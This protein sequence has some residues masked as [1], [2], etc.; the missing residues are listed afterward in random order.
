[1]LAGILF[2]TLI[3]VV[4]ALI[5]VDVVRT[6]TEAPAG[7]A[8][9]HGPERAAVGARAATEV[10]AFSREPAGTDKAAARATGG[11]RFGTVPAEMDSVGRPDEAARTFDQMRREMPQSAASDAALRSRFSAM[12]VNLSR[13]SQA[14][15]ERQ[16]RL[17]ESL[18]HGEQDQHRLATL[19]KLNRIA[20]R[21]HRNSQNLLVLAGQE[22]VSS[23]NQPVTL[24]HLVEA[25]LAEIEDY[26]RV[27]FEVQPDIALR[28][29]AVHDAV[30]LL[31]ELIDNAT[32]FSAAEMPVHITGRILTTGGALVDITDRGIGMPAKEMAYANQQLDNPP[33]PETDVPKWMGL[34]VVARLAARH[35]IRVRLNPTDI[36]GL[37][38]LVWFPD[39][40]LTRY[41][42]PADP[43]RAVVAQ[44]AAAVGPAAFAGSRVNMPATLAARPDPAWS[45]AGSPTIP[46]EPLAAAKLAAPVRA[47]AMSG[48]FGLVM[49]DAE[50]QARLHGPPIYDEVE[51]R[52]S[53]GGREA[54]GSRGPVTPPGPITSSGAFRSA[55]PSTSTG[56]SAPPRPV[57]SPGPSASPGPA[58]ASGPVTSSRPSASPGPS[59]SPRPATSPD[60]AAS[61]RPAASPGPAAPARPA[62]AP[63]P[64]MS[65]GP[66]TPPSPSVSPGLAPSPNLVAPSGPIA[67]SGQVASPSSVASPDPAVA[68]APA[69]APGSAASPGSVASPEPA[70]ADS[71]SADPAA[72]PLPRRPPPATAGPRAVPGSPPGTPNR[73]GAPARDPRT[74]V[75]RG[76]SPGWAGPADEVN[77]GGQEES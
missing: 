50:S 10:A 60:S 69:V 15:V 63:G 72:P 37:T 25:A 17:I 8:L 68:P 13:R 22:P 47:D 55:R 56:S 41:A 2:L 9:G 19:A 76:G 12:S 57:T 46:A 1:M 66:V 39:E 62:A 43:G 33:P 34:L 53:R 32:S 38:A 74:A 65:P 28:G 67:P 4:A 73:A 49:A 3:L 27:S 77:P 16:L 42:A 61:P 45:A 11:A 20:V 36:G 54:P 23:W 64:S 6:P 30:H 14:L 44:R 75:Q 31:V 70:S 24:A 5:T 40:I 48:D 35:G 7:Q 18:E 21:M 29:P 51:S 58:A 52:W 71:T 59:A 26:E